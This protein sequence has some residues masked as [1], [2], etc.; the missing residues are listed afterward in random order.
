[1]AR[2]TAFSRQVDIAKSQLVGEARRQALIAAARNA[3]DEAQRKNR[4]ALGKDPTFETIV[5][6]RRGAT[7]ESVRQ[8]GTIVYLFAVGATTLERAVDDTIN[9][10]HELSPVLTG[11][12]RSHHL[13]LVNGVERD[14]GREVNATAGGAIRLEDS[15]AVTFVNLLPYS[16]KIEHGWSH[17]APNGVYEAAMAS[18][19][20]R[21]GSVLR[22]EF[23]YERFP[24]RGPRAAVSGRS[25]SAQRRDDS[26]PTIRLSVK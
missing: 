2:V 12:Y 6:G 16:R 24:G 26:F 23:T 19:R 10:L 22:V 1:M 4:A 15:D 14:A 8:G 17:Q 9:L 18:I 11:A 13:F 20:A 7:V 21:Y 25:R 3:F 5:D